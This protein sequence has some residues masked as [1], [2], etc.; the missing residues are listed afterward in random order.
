MP[1]HRELL[2]QFLEVDKVPKEKSNTLVITSG[3]LSVGGYFTIDNPGE[4]ERHQDVTISSSVSEYFW[5][6][7]IEL[8]EKKVVELRQQQDGL[9]I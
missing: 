6:D 2:K 4:K 7:V 5:Q 1:K 9:E 3:T 8:L